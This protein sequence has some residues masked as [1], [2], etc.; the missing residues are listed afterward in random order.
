MPL[1]NSNAVTAVP[2]TGGLEVR[3][4]VS[5]HDI[6]AAQALR[7]RVFHEELGATL[8]GNIPGRDVDEFD[9]ACDH[10][11]ILDHQ[12]C[13]D[14]AVIGTYRLLRR[15]VAERH[16]GFYTET[17][18]DIR[19]LLA[20]PGEL[21]ELGRSCVDPAY[22]NRAT[23]Q[24][25]WRGISAYVLRHG[26]SLMFGC[27]SLPGTD[28]AALAPA[29]TYLHQQHLAPPALR[30]R[31]LPDRYV[32]MDCMPASSVSPD[33][34]AKPLESR[35][36]VAG[37]PPLLKG[38]LRLGGFVGDGAVIDHAFKTTDVCLIVAV[39]EVSAKYANH[40]LHRLG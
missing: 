13:P 12:A 6:D 38:Y 15:S 7:Y 29:L 11:V 34:A 36:A 27:A 18:F 33:T 8:A 21:L 35:A 9:T 5:A 22:R 3:L 24:L 19:P 23:M 39:D 32:A 1:L 4:A 16:G 25:L 20:Q 17:E 30:A 26:V 10:L 28:V 2:G 40:F 31:A 37:L 14:G